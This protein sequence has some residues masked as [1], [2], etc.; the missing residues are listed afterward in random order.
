MELIEP[1]SKYDD[2]LN[3]LKKQP[4]QELIALFEE[5]IVSY[6]TTPL[7]TDEQDDIIKAKSEYINNETIEWK[8]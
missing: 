1:I 5:L 4:N 3:F 8:I 7:S 2:L 6:D